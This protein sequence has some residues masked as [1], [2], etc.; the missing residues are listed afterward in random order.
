MLADYAS[1]IYGHHWFALSDAR[2]ECFLRNLWANATGWLT[3]LTAGAMEFTQLIQYRW[4]K[5]LRQIARNA[6][7]A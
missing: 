3:L 4:R 7:H 2:R 6:P 5:R 1:P